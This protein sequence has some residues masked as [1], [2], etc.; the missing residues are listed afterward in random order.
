MMLSEII[1][2]IMLETGLFVSGDITNLGLTYKQFWMIV[3]RALGIYNKYKPIQKKSLILT[4]NN[5]Y[6]FPDELA[7][8]FITSAY[9]TGYGYVN[10]FSII[11]Y[12]N[13]SSG[14]LPQ[15]VFRYTKPELITSLSGQFEI[16]GNYH[17][18]CE[19]TYCDPEGTVID[20]VEISDL[21][22][23]DNYF[24][25]L[26]EALFLQLVGKFTKFVTQADS[27]TVFDSDALIEDGKSKYEEA[28]QNIQDTSKWYMA[29]GG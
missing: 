27:S 6:R 22:D 9:P 1:D 18:Y 23:A 16:T 3:K 26:V 8:E 14:D 10:P 7:P 19:I 17:R 25:D 29:I 4:N 2:Q 12:A 11:N 24:F 21:Y 15:V 28:L 5:F 13:E 20:D